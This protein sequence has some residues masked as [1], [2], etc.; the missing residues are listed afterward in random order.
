M[1]LSFPQN[2]FFDADGK[3]LVGRVTF[4]VHDSDTEADVYTLT[5][6]TYTQT[7]GMDIFLAPQHVLMTTYT[8]PDT[9]YDALHHILQSESGTVRIVYVGYDF[10]IHKNSDIW[11]NGFQHHGPTWIAFFET[12]MGTCAHASCTDC[13][14][15]RKKSGRR[16]MKTTIQQENTECRPK[17]KVQWR[18]LYGKTY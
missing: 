9:E 3:P 4:Y 2:Q 16:H 17:Y 8:Y 7:Y 1:Y 6:T 10:Q 5:G 14:I 11:H 15:R 12:K 18:R 13:G